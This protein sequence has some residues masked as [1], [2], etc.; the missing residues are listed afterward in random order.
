[1]VTSVSK[2]Q[3]PN[4]LEPEIGQRLQVR[5]PDGQTVP[6]WVSDVT[7]TEVKLD[8]NHPL[9]GKTLT[10]EIELLEVQ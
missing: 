5:R 2:D 9:A 3:L 8:A 1:M 7:E 4:D 10:F 6:V